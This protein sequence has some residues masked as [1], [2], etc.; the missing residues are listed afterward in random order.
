MK[1]VLAILAFALLFCPAKAD[2]SY[3]IDVP[4]I[5]DAPF[6]FE[7]AVKSFS[8]G[9]NIVK[10][11]EVWDEAYKFLT[12]ELRENAS[13]MLTITGICIIYALLSSMDAGFGKANVSQ[14]AFFAVYMT[15]AGLGT[16]AFGDIAKLGTNLINDMVRL[17]NTLIPVMGASI[18]SSGSI[19]VYTATAPL[20]LIMANAA[21]NIINHI[22]MPAVF[23]SLALSIAGNISPRF[24]LASLAGTV[25]KAAFWIVTAAMTVF[26]ALVGASGLGSGALGG[27]AA[28]ALKF[29]VGSGV[30][31]LGSV[32]S[33]SVEAVA[34]GAAIL[35]N[36]IGAAGITFM[37]LMVLFPILKITAVIIIYKL[38]ACIAGIFADK[39]IVGVL[40]DLSASLA[41][42]IGFAV[43]VCAALIIAV[44]ILTS[45]SGTGGAV[46]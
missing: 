10:A 16:A 42:I 19:G 22:G 30:P 29:A 41:C 23:L 12:E 27:A 35:K 28:K 18:V 26:C 43:S 17:Q 13:V 14:T 20:I 24:P 2:E 5:Y 8:E 46:L 7:S 39:R 31:V 36:A 1:R 40:N 11:D 3:N 45:A 33:D 44:S 32:L 25:R 4:M 15:V 21:G 34:F 9:K 6:S 37:L 38:S